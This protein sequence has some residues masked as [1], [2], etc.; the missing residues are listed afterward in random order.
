MNR[1]DWQEAFGPAPDAFRDRVDATLNRLEE[2]EMRRSVKFSTALVAA[3]LVTVLLAGAAFAASQLNIWEA[4]NYADPIIPLKGAD[5]LVTTDLASAENDYFRM[6]VQEGVYDGYGTIVKLRC[7]PK[8]PEKYAIIT[9]L[10]VPANLG[11]EYITEVVRVHEDGMK[12]ER[13]TGRKDGKEVIFLSTPRLIVNGESPNGE[14]MGY[15]HLFNSYRDQYNNDGSAEF[16]IS[17][18]SAHNLPDTL[19]VVLSVYG[20]DVNYSDAYGSIEK[21]TFELVKNNKERTV[22]L[23]PSEDAKVDGFELIDAQITFTEVRGYIVVEF[24]GS[25]EEQ[26]MGVSL[27][28]LDADGNQITTGGGQC[29]QLENGHYRWEMEMQSFEEI[30]DILILEVK[31]ID[32]DP[33]GCIECTVEPVTE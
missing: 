13:I 11:D 30:P 18:M 25:S 23:T 24:T 31:M 28:L 26:G 16:W 10:A 32:G 29:M 4:L 14:A 27:N 15:E 6:I 21:L 8:D 20:R 2:R 22:R 7:E 33:I 12:E 3:V 19:N 5:D 1:N 9:D 17:G